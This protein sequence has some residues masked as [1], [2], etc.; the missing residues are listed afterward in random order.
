MREENGPV[1][2]SDVHASSVESELV[3]YYVVRGSS[4]R[5]KCENETVLR[6]GHTSMNCLSMYL[7]TW[8]VPRFIYIYHYVTSISITITHISYTL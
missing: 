4:L 6:I 1:V 2:Q 8:F 3:N 7:F 5:L